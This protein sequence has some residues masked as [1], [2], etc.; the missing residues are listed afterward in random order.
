MNIEILDYQPSDKPFIWETYVKSMKS[1][2]EKIWGWNDSWQENDFEQGFVKYETKVIKLNQSTIGYF[3]LKQETEFTYISMFV[4]KPK[5]QSKGIGKIVLNYLQ[6]KE[7][8]NHL[9]LNCF[10]I[11]KRAYNF[12]IKCGFKVIKTDNDFIYLQRNKSA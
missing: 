4:L 9:R 8:S 2:I 7:P 12:Y 1:Y 6:P 3:Q 5:Y 11:N 10:K